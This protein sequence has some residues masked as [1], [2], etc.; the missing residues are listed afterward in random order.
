VIIAMEKARFVDAL[1]IQGVFSP[2]V[3]LPDGTRLPCG[4]IFARG[5]VPNHFLAP[6][7][8]SHEWILNRSKNGSF[9]I[10][11]LIDSRLQGTP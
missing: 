11:F 6:N 7:F 8:G 9:T 10:G 4:M 2:C 3:K 1:A 5:N